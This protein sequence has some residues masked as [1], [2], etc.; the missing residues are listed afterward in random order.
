MRKDQ[1]RLTQGMLFTDLYQLTMAQVYFRQGLHQKKVRFEYF[2]RRNPDY[3]LHQ[4]GYCIFAGLEWLIEWM[5]ETK[6]QDEDLEVLRDLRTSSGENLFAADF[7]EWLKGA[8]DFSGISLWAVAEGR[9]VHPNVPLIVVEGPFAMAQI[10][11][12][13]LLNHLNYQTLVATKAVRIKQAGMGKLLL[14]FGMRRAHELGAI[15]GTRAAL[16]GGA[17]F[18]SNVGTSVVLGFPPK[19]TH[20]HSL[21]QAFMAIGEGELSAFRA[22]AEIYPDDCLLLVDTINTLHSGVPHAIKVFEELR[23]KGHRPLGIRLD[24]GDLA[25]LSIQS[26]KMLCE[27][28][29]SECHIVLSNQLDELIITQIITQIQQEA[30][31]AGIHPEQL[32]DHLIF[33]VGT[34]LI[35]SSGQSALDGVYKLTALAEGQSWRPAIKVSETPAKTVNPGFKELWRLYDQRKKAVGDLLCL[36]GEELLAMEKIVLHHPVDPDR[37][38]ILK[39]SEIAEMEKLL[40]PVLENGRRLGNVPT[41]EAMRKRR[42]ADTSCLDLGVKRLINPHIYHVSLSEKLWEL[43]HEVLRRQARVNDS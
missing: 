16:I 9:V 29:F 39:K 32:I 7:L 18:S 20:S 2:Y 13:A 8:G 34:S 21:V 38:R 31:A 10:L 11:E 28:G 37:F 22:F 17:D 43:K 1:Q 27:A 24:S 3:G 4:A 5:L 42:Q 6:F 12:T 26:Y 14:D 25:Y 36:Q 19:G 41:I 33:G 15:A 30:P 23:R 35:T 40:E